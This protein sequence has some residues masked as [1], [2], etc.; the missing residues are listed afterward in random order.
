MTETDTLTDQTTDAAPAKTGR[1]VGYPK[2]GGRKVGTSN[3]TPA[4][5]QAI[6][7]KHSPD[8]V[9]FLVKV[10]L[11][12]RFSRGS[13]WVYPSSHVRTLAA[14]KVLD[15]AEM[16][17]KRNLLAGQPLQVNILIGALPVPQIAPVSPLAPLEHV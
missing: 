7:N 9:S 2:S 8:A 6:A 11:G 14:C 16:P 5:A 15:I 17:A 12:Q 10:M 13:E 1:P 3:K 4:L